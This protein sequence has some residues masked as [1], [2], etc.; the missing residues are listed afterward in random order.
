MPSWFLQAL[1]VGVAVTLMAR[2]IYDLLADVPTWAGSLKSWRRRRRED[3]QKEE[4][5]QRLGELQQRVRSR[6]ESLDIDL[7]WERDWGWAAPGVCIVYRSGERSYFINAYDHGIG[8]YEAALRSGIVPRERTFHT[9]APK[10]V[11][12]WSEKEL[13][14]WLDQH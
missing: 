6:S 9:P 2:L 1:I 7:P 12:D 14:K 13:N 5:R 10:P 11:V 4:K 8:Q 3:R